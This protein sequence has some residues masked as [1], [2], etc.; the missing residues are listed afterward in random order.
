MSNDLSQESLFLRLCDDLA[1][2]LSSND[3]YR[4]LSISR[5]IRQLLLDGHSSLIH[6][7]NTHYKKKILFNIGKFDANEE[8][9]FWSIQDGLDP[10]TSLQTRESVSVTLDKFLST[11][12]VRADGKNLSIADLVRFEA[13][14]GGG[15]HAGTPKSDDER[16]LADIRAIY[17]GGLPAGFRQLKAVARVVLKGLSELQSEVKNH[18]GLIGGGIFNTTADNLVRNE[19]NSSI[20]GAIRNT[21]YVTKEQPPILPG[22]ESSYHFQSPGYIELGLL[23]DFGS[24]MRD[25]FSF[26]L[27]IAPDLTTEQTIFG[28]G[29]SGETSLALYVNHGGIPGRLLIEVGDDKGR[30]LRGYAQTSRLAS[31]RLAVSVAPCQNIIAMYELSTD[32]NDPELAVNI[33]DKQGPCEFSDFKY[34]LLMS[35]KNVSGHRIGSFVGR[36]AEFA[37]FFGIMPKSSVEKFL[38][39]TKEHIE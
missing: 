30:M 25:G 26:L 19:K 11:I 6:Q 32:Q 1:G 27:D 39:A 33:F 22:S 12:I 9:T 15:V 17:V 8:A 35:G 23:G 37:I 10:E 29:A 20:P 14:V 24:R 2:L 3:T 5:I 38:T 7:V 36:M 21:D 18:H 31:K 13:N 34:P 16:I 28:T 4:L